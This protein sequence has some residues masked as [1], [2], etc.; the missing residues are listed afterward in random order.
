MP[1]PA[2][3]ITDPEILKGLTHPLRRRIFRLLAEFGPATVTAL[4]ERT[5]ADPGRLS[6]HLREL[7]RRGFIEEAP[8]L[9]RDRR[10][11][12]WKLVPG[13]VSWSTSQVTGPDGQAVAEALLGMNVAE[14]FERLRAYQ[15]SRDTWDPDW[16][17]AATT[18]ETYLRLTPQ[19]L[20]D[21]SVELNALL[22]RWAEG[23][24]DASRTAAADDGRESVMLFLH[25]FPEKP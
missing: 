16:V 18:S 22:A 11:R 23:R 8:E 6:Y 3:K 7:G 15:A 13:G 20:R 5:G 12:W 21:L 19:E 25:A 14:Q 4:A 2:R 1:H 9:A 24:F 17:D 10:E